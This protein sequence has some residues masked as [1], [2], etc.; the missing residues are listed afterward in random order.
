M[1]FCCCMEHLSNRKTHDDSWC[2]SLRRLS[3]CHTVPCLSPLLAPEDVLRNMK[4]LERNSIETPS[5]K[6]KLDENS[7]AL[8]DE[9]CTAIGAS[10]IAPGPWPVM[11]LESPSMGIACLTSSRVGTCHMDESRVCTAG[12]PGRSIYMPVPRSSRPGGPGT[13]PSPPHTTHGTAIWADQA[14]P[15]EYSSWVYGRSLGGH[16]FFW[17]TWRVP[18]VFGCIPISLV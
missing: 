14:S 8:P 1:C 9:L 10:T 13:R 7:P 4:K 12:S 17:Y 6:S 5:W 3:E 18:T 15:M 2:E 16:S 11:A